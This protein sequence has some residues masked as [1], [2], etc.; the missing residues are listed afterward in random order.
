MR[1]EATVV[2]AVDPVVITEVAQVAG[3][4]DHVVELEGHADFGHKALDE[5]AER[6]AIPEVFVLVELSDKALTE[7]VRVDLVR[8]LAIQTLVEA[9]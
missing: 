8:V 4:G 5:V 1:G 7:A 3:V 9:L 2:P 6:V